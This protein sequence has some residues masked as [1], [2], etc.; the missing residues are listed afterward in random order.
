LTFYAGEVIAVM[1]R[2]GVDGGNVDD[3]WWRG[4]LLPDGPVRVFPSLV[5]QESGPN[6]EDLSPSRVL[7]MMRCFIFVVLLSLLRIYTFQRVY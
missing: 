6:G 3:G 2:S 4:K 5:V 7:Y 1:R